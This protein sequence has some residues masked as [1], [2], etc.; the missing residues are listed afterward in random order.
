MDKGAPSDVGCSYAANEDSATPLEQLRPLV[1]TEAI[2]GRPIASRFADLL[3]LDVPTVS[4]T[5]TVFVH[6]V[7]NPRAGHE[8]IRDH[9]YV[10]GTTINGDRHRSQACIK[11]GW[12][13]HRRSSKHSMTCR[14]Q[15]SPE[16]ALR[17]ISWSW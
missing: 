10:D 9:A 5:L 17:T 7:G 2:T 11:L 3:T 15:L 1:E 13:R 12:Y 4:L 6:V 16:P 14:S 8:P